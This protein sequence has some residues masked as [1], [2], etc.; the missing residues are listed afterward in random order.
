[1]KH[2]LRSGLLLF[3]GADLSQG[4]LAQHLVIAFRAESCTLYTTYQSSHWG[5]QP[6]AVRC[7]ARGLGACAMRWICRAAQQACIY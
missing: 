6:V 3:N 4:T 5:M 7:T 1:M 2:N